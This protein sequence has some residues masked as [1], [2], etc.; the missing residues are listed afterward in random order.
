MDEH[1]PLEGLVL[2]GNMSL[3][4]VKVATQVPMIPNSEFAFAF[5]FAKGA[6]LVDA[7]LDVPN[8]SCY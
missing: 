1:G 3:L 7:F 8:G 4:K 5:G 6:E 2:L